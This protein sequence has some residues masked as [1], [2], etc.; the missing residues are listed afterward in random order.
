MIKQI[1]NNLLKYYMGSRRSGH[2][3]VM[4]NGLSKTMQKIVLITISEK[5]GSELSESTRAFADTVN[6]PLSS[7]ESSKADGLNIPA[8]FDNSAILQLLT[9][10]SEHFDLQDERLMGMRDQYEYFRNHLEHF[11][12][13]LI[14]HHKLGL[15]RPENGVIFPTDITQ[16]VLYRLTTDENIKQNLGKMVRQ[17]EEFIVKISSLRSYLKWYFK[18][19]YKGK[20]K[21]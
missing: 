11:Q 19:L 6:M 16:A 1:V 2:T 12:N 17:R 5:Y 15:K 7:F 8:A 14:D 4:I 20:R 13:T 10:V 9:M 18:T 21:R 3:T